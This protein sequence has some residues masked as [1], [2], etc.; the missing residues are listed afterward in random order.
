MSGLHLETLP[1]DRLRPYPRNARTYSKKQ[2][3]QIGESIRTFG[4]TNPVPDE[5]HH[6]Q[7]DDLGARL[8][9]AEDARAAHAGKAI[10]S[11]FARQP[12]LL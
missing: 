8:E 7:A 10:G 12:I 5:H 2:L 1:V 3:G 4:F 11:R 6:R 9:V